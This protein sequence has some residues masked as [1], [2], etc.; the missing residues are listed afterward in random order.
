[1]PDNISDVSEKI[2]SVYDMS[3]RGEL[4]FNVT[5]ILVA[6]KDIVYACDRFKTTGDVIYDNNRV[7]CNLFNIDT[8][9]DGEYFVVTPGE[10]NR[11]P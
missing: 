9:H 3:P 11:L 5:V 7:F 2:M 4:V 10:Y 8:R 6:E 1:M